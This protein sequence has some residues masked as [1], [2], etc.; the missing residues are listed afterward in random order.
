MKIE[1]STVLMFLNALKD[2]KFAIGKFQTSVISYV[3][4]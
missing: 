4:L 1:K 3:Q 2:G